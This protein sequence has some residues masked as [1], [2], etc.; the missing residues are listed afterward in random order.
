LDP[1]TT[2]AFAVVDYLFIFAQIYRMDVFQKSL[3][4]L[5]N[6]RKLPVL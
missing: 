5:L 6:V 1:G 3:K 2:Q 4:D